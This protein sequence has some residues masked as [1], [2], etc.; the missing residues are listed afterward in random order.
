[1][2]DEDKRQLAHMVKHQIELGQS[3]TATVKRLSG[4][5]FKQYT[6]RAYYKTFSRE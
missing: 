3:M 1:M 2:K 4:M 6:I 5:G